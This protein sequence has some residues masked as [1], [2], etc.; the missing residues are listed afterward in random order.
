MGNVKRNKK[1]KKW[2][3]IGIILGVAFVIDLLIPDP[4]PFI[5]EVIL[6]AGTIYA[7]IKNMKNKE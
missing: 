2:Q 3:T 4:L 5:D 7:G 6:L 1:E